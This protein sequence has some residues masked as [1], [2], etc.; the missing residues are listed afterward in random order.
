MDAKLL[1]KIKALK[2]ELATLA[3][4]ERDEAWLKA[5]QDS[6]EGRW[7]KFEEGRTALDLVLPWS[8]NLLRAELKLRVKHSEI[9]E[10]HQQHLK[11]LKGVEEHLQGR[12]RRRQD[13]SLRL[14]PDRLLPHRSRDLVGGS[15]SRE[16]RKRA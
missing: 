9:V 12:F 13:S 10:A 1:E 14:P 6:W 15:E 8:A 3:A 2:A 11:R 16:V 5:A 7:K 4:H